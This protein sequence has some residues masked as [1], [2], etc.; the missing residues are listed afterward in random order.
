M[1]II[2]SALRELRREIDEYNRPKEAEK[3]VEIIAG[4]FDDNTLTGPQIGKQIYF[5]GMVVKLN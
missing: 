4:Y 5:T 1:S 2:K 3:W